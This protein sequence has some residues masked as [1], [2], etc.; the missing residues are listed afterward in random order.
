MTSCSCCEVPFRDFLVFL[1]HSAAAS[2][3]D[4]DAV[5]YNL[6]SAR[7]N[8]LLRRISKD[9]TNNLIMSHNGNSKNN[10]NN[11]EELVRIGSS[12]TKGITTNKR[13]LS[14]A[15]VSRVQSNP[16]DPFLMIKSCNCGDNYSADRNQIH[17][18][19]TT[20]HI[21]H[22]GGDEVS[23]SSSPSSGTENKTQSNPIKK[24]PQR[25][26][27]ILHQSI[28]NLRSSSSSDL[29]TTTSIHEVIPN[30]SRASRKTLKSKSNNNNNKLCNN[31]NP[32]TNDE[33]SY[34]SSFRE[35][36]GDTPSNLIKPVNNKK[37]DLEGKK[38][39]R[40]KSKNS[41]S[42][43]SVSESRD[44]GNDAPSPEINPPV[45]IS[46]LDNNNINND[47][48]Q[49][50][51]SSSKGSSSL[52]LNEPF[53]DNHDTTNKPELKES[54]D[55]LCNNDY[56]MVPKPRAS[57]LSFYKNFSATT[58]SKS[59]LLEEY[60]SFC[61]FDSDDIDHEGNSL[62]DQDDHGRHQCN[63]NNNRSKQQLLIM[64]QRLS[65]S[66]PTR[67]DLIHYN[68]TYSNHTA[69]KNHSGL[70]EE[71][72]QLLND[73]HRQ[74][75]EFLKSN[76]LFHLSPDSGG[77]LLLNSDIANVSG[78]SLL[79]NSGESNSDDD[80]HTTAS[81]IQLETFDESSNLFVGKVRLGS[82]KNST[83][84][85]SEIPPKALKGGGDLME[86]IDIDDKEVF[87]NADKTRRINTSPSDEINHEIVP[88]RKSRSDQK[89]CLSASS[90]GKQRSKSSPSG[91][92]S[93][94]NAK[95]TRTK[96]TVTLDNAS[97]FLDT[98]YVNV[99]Q[100]IDA[101]SSIKLY[102]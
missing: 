81:P 70:T 95:T 16:D 42:L 94:S 72:E 33:P 65:R 15:D 66:T 82:S 45:T 35:I 34:Y 48:E 7:K 31:C 30:K 1:F 51:P 60:I 6:S 18:L 27:I 47:E 63:N 4:H 2:Q 76:E 86:A 78:H 97:L 87:E 43:L 101:A 56:L 58:R 98:V 50:L 53:N 10:N 93:S 64:S 13:S 67:L 22:S 57:D 23:P 39:K 24:V 25:Q 55:N 12:L 84:P 21:E 20:V 102:Y 96:V 46:K 19:T 40:S 85:S 44:N 54:S 92:S 28:S 90:Q 62:K 8:L 74:I 11:R 68:R 41:K 99:K 88:R 38:P 91:S 36:L 75:E 89:V 49:L 32:K 14:N 52:L 73:H 100:N 9:H 61:K 3:N 77:G 29:H 37:A 59:S 71:E 80:D 83:R 17:L 79:D 26:K 69:I 5:E